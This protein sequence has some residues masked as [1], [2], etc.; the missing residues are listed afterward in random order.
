MAQTL[1]FSHD[2][3]NNPLSHPKNYWKILIFLALISACIDVPSARAQLQQPFVF[4]SGGAVAVRNDQ[5]G[6]LTPVSNSPF[7]TPSQ[8]PASGFTIDVQGRFLFAIGT[9]SIRMFQIT[10]STTGAFQEVCDSPFASPTT[11]QPMFIAVEPTGQYIAVVNRVGKNPGDASVETFLIAPSAPISC[12]DTNVGPALVPVQGSATELDS[13]PIGVAQPPNNEEFLIFMGPNAQ[14]QNPTIQEGSEFQGLSIDP[15]TGFITGLGAGAASDERG[16]SFAMDPQGRYYVTGTQDN[17]LEI[18]NIRTFGIGGQ[19]L[20]FNVTL[21][22]NFYP[23]GLWIDS[24]GSFI[25]ALTSNLNN[26]AVVNIYSMNLQTGNF[27]LTASSPLPEATSI[28]VY[29]PDPTGSFNY[30]SGADANT[31]IAYTVDPVTGYFIQTA[32]SPFT[33]PQIAGAFTFSIPPGQQG[34]SGPSASLSAPS[35][36]FGSVQT[37]S[38]SM[39]QTIALTSNGGQALSVNSI[40]LSGADS[41]QFFET[42][43]CQAPSVLQPNKFCSISVIFTPNASGTGSQQAT[44]TIIDNAPGSPQ[45]V[46]L[47]GL[48]VAPPPPA[49]AVTASPDP[50]SFPT[51]TQGT[52]SSPITLVV[53]NSGSAALQLTSVAIGGNNMGDFTTTNACTSGSLATKATCNITVTFAPLAAGERTETI[54]LTDNASDSPQVINVGGNANPALTTGPAPNGSTSQ[55]VAPGQTAQF[56]LQMTPGPGYTGVVSLTYSGAPTGASIQ[57]PST[58]QISNGNAAPF[59]VMVTT[60]GGAMM[61]PFSDA[62]RTT[63]FPGQPFLL[64]VAGGILLLVLVVFSANAETIQRPKRTALGAAFASLILFATLT[65]AGCGGGSYATTPPP[66]VVTPQGQSMIAVVPAATSASGKPLQLQAIQL[67]LNVN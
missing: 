14:S 39:P 4:S 41:G 40:A 47:S 53:T 11:N 1:A 54:T 44:V 56:N 37:G 7:L 21:N 18:G 50:V 63:P 20:P 23:I 51:I 15:Q 13:T 10:D 3:C 26:P 38:S 58:L 36:S 27:T 31:A 67:T 66:P 35:L 8:A 57:G 29:Y 16:D 9:N 43:T 30:G 55:T 45:S 46:T 60:S 28:P 48:G 2:P 52:T 59:T 24:T 65:T 62:L 22:Q 6:A 33:I 34:V 61:L 49:P 32:N 12:P 25:Y 19:V 42:D 5:T 17:V 64:A